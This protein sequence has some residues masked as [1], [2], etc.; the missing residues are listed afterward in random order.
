MSAG[1]G[2]LHG[3]VAIVTGG[4]S[5]IG[6][7]T[8][9]RFIAEEAH[10][11][12]TDLQVERGRALAEETNSLFIEHDVSDEAGWQRVVETTTKH[13]GR[14]DV[15]MNNAGIVSGK[16]IEDVDLATW[17]RVLAVNLTGAMMGC[18]YGISAMRD[19]GGALINVASTSAFAAIPGD[20]SYSS[21]KFA[22][23][24]L[25]R[26][27]AVHCA[28]AGYDIR[29]N[30][31]VP[32][33]TETPI[34]GPRLASDPN[35][36]AAVT[37]MSPLGR[38]GQGSDVAAMAVFLASDEARYCTGADFIVDGGLLAGHPGM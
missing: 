8:V 33:A 14:L 7:A 3:K 23:R 32:G 12:L 22:I 11:V 29:C 34:L 26:S 36:R 30:A 16:S 24:G 28:R 38:L 35:F 31:L 13:F 15:V 19:K 18:R 20:V 5:G 27:I 9:R 10:V 25:T 21:S 37:K 6:A 4:A 1:R 2:R 17:Q